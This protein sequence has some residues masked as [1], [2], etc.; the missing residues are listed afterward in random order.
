LTASTGVR[1]SPGAPPIVPRMPEI[2]L[3]KVTV[4]I[5]KNETSNLRK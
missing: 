5:F 4:W 1:A 3:I 2:D